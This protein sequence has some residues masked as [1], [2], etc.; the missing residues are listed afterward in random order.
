MNT[1][2]F[3]QDKIYFHKIQHCYNGIWTTDKHYYKIT[4]RTQKTIWFERVDRKGKTYIHSITSLDGPTELYNEEKFKGYV[5]VKQLEEN[6]E[7]LISEAHETF[8][9][10]FKWNSRNITSLNVLPKKVIKIIKSK[11][12]EMSIAIEEEHE[13]YKCMK[14]MLVSKRQAG[15]ISEKMFE[16]FMRGEQQK[17]TYLIREIQMEG[18]VEGYY[19]YT[20]NSDTPPPY[21]T[22]E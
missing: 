13:R 4:K 21:S 12:S 1:N 14:K 7:R 19:N 5:R 6:E 3:E 16:K 15:Q 18:G 9:L 8:T 20:T 22:I 10:K 2:A 11:K 17:H